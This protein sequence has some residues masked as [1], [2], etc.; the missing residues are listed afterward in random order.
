M[1]QLHSG[2]LLR[3][4]YVVLIDRKLGLDPIAGAGTGTNTGTNTS[5]LT[6]D[7]AIVGVVV[8]SLRLP[9]AEVVLGVVQNLAGLGSVVV[10]GLGVTGDNRSVVKKLQQAA[11]VLG[12]DNLLLGTLNSG[13]E[14]GLV[15]FLELLASL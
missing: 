2:G 10:D 3:G 13:G 11:T 14:L 6:G 9:V 8:V 12:Q 1:T 15:G 5:T 7:T 4:N